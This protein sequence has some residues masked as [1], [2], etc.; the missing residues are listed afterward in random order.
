M[1]HM[2]QLTKPA[3]ANEKGVVDDDVFTFGLIFCLLTGECDL[4]DIKDIFRF[5]ADFS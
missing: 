2:N 3:L 1:R 5:L 4:G